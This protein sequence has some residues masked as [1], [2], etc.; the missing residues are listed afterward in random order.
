MSEHS[1]RAGEIAASLPDFEK[2]ECHACRNEG[3]TGGCRSCEGDGY[4]WLRTWSGT[5]FSSRQ[6]VRYI[7]DFEDYSRGLPTAAI[8]LA[9]ATLNRTCSFVEG[10][11]SLHV[12]LEALNVDRQDPTLAIFQRI[13]SMAARWLEGR[14]L[15]R[16]GPKAPSDLARE[17]DAHCAESWT[18]V[19][20][21]C[22]RVIRLLSR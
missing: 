20:Q 7:E 14:G 5:A 21:G 8:E 22:E 13:D 6:L 19:R 17:L 16:Y 9:R 2:I 12:L 15:V 1:K 10:C 3:Q 4:L 18:A 11:R